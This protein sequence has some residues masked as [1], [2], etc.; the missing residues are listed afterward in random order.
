MQTNLHLVAKAPPTDSA[1]EDGLKSVIVNLPDIFFN[2]RRPPR[3][4][5]PAI[6]I[7]LF[8]VRENPVDFSHGIIVRVAIRDGHE[9]H[10]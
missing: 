3:R 6:L 4:D 8:S 10:A 5:S 7:L 2:H 1:V 9:Y